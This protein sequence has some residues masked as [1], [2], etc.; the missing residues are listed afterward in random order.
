MPR[1][2]HRRHPRRVRALRIQRGWSQEVL[3]ELAGLHRNYIGHVEWA[4]IN[5][6]VAHLTRMAESRRRS[7]FAPGR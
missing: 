2:P 5:L 1:H 7:G 6:S 4:E 3:A